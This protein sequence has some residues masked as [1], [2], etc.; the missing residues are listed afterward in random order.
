MK[1]SKKFEDDYKF[2][3]R[4]KDVFNFDGS[5]CY[6][7]KKGIDIIQHDVKGKTAKECFYLYDSNGII[8]KT[9]E[10]FELRELLKTKGSVNLHI[11]M[12]AQDRAKGYLPK[13]EFNKI[14][15]ELDLPIWFIEAVENQKFKYY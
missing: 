15:K 9:S 11:K 8:A 1:Y 3:L 14:C 12:Y 6:I 10:P 2:Y 5:D 4:V 7:N 13:I